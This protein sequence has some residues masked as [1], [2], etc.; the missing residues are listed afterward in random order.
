MPL[1]GDKKPNLR[2]ADIIS[3][4][5]KPRRPTSSKAPFH[6]PVNAR[7]HSSFL[8]YKPPPRPPSSYQNTIHQHRHRPLPSLSGS[9]GCCTRTKLSSPCCNHLMA[10]GDDGRVAV[11]AAHAVVSVLWFSGHESKHCLIHPFPLHA[12][13]AEQQYPTSKVRA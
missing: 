2:K 1:T 12:G 5:K 3:E 4:A 6:L 10:F 11:L 13:K 7:L 8:S 9:S